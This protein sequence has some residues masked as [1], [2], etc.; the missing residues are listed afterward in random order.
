MTAVR[1]E[2]PYLK[3]DTDRHGNIR[4]YVR[5]GGC[6]IRIREPKGS[7][8]FARAYAEAVEALDHPGCAKA[9]RGIEPAPA[10]TLGALAASYFASRRFMALDLKSQATRRLVIEDCLREP[11]RALHR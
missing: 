10:G 5:R 11:R 4:I 1:V 7:P 8:G 6:K 9:R 2:F 3:E